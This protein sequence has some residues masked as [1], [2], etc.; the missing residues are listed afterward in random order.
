MLI[1]FFIT[2]GNVIYTAGEDSRVL[3]TSYPDF[4]FLNY[5]SRNQM[6]VQSIELN[7]DSSLMAVASLEDEIK[8][9]SLNENNKVK[10]LKGHE[11]GVIAVAFD[12]KGKYIASAGRDGNIKIWN[13]S[14]EKETMTLKNMIPKEIIKG[15]IDLEDGKTS[16]ILYKMQWN[17]EGKYLIIPGG[18]KGVFLIEREKWIVRRTVKDEKMECVYMIAYSNKNHMIVAADTKNQCFMFDTETSFAGIQKIGEMEDQIT[19][20]TWSPHDSLLIIV[21]NKSFTD[22]F[23][24]E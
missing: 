20:L 16:P 24:L 12:P 7:S 14:E 22:N 11:G 23:I 18:S 17:S 3:S 19:N 10:T 5:I 6:P 1:Y 9:I 13:L 4:T 8:I 2:K 21:R 15:I